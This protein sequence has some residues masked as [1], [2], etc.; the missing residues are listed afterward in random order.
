MAEAAQHT[1]VPRTNIMRNERVAGTFEALPRPGSI[2]WGLDLG[3]RKPV[4]FN[5]DGQAEIK[6]FYL[7]E[8]SAGPGFSLPGC[9]RV[10][11]QTKDQAGRAIT[12]AF[13]TED[14][15]Y[16]IPGNLMKPGNTIIVMKAVQHSFSD[17]QI[18]IRV[19]ECSDV[20][21]DQFL[22]ISD[23]LLGYVA[24]GKVAEKTCHKCKRKGTDL[25]C[26]SKCRLVWY[27][28]MADRPGWHNRECAI[29]KA[30]KMQSLLEMDWDE[31][32]DSDSD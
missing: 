18:G 27:C 3:S 24:A 32:S 26:C 5:G 14:R 4:S 7:G 12:V 10:V 21:L 2:S 22:A 8:I 9:V 23:R 28:N 31:W 16:D 29:I 20:K 13:Y 17:G 11:I 19:K 30:G 6:W 15:G 1:R 25:N